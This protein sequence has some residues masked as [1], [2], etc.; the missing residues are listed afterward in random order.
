MVMICCA[1]VVR[2]FCAT[3]AYSIIKFFTIVFQK[4]C[5]SVVWNNWFIQELYYSQNQLSIFRFSFNSF[6]Y[7]RY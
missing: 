2:E 3:S 7:R 5:S 1:V 4:F 6:I